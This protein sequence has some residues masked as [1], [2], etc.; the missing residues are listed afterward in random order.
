MTFS[1]CWP[2]FASPLV[3]E[4]SPWFAVFFIV[5]VTFGVFAMIRIIS[6]LFLEETLAQASRDADMMVREGSKKTAALAKD[7]TDL[8]ESADKSGDGMV[9]QEELTNLLMHPKVKL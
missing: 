9:S 1:G 7:L 8:F 5:Y 6:A 3:R 4:V 2:N